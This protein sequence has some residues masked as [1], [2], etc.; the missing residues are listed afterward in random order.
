MMPALLDGTAATH[1]C[2]FVDPS[3]SGGITKGYV[4]PAEAPGPR[5]TPFWIADTIS[6][7]L[8]GYLE[9]SIGSQLVWPMSPDPSSLCTLLLPI[10]ICRHCRF[11]SPRLC[12]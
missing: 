9:S 8:I 3:A 11:L 12:P 7:L 6:K 2:P 10:A 1:Q 4:L 5:K